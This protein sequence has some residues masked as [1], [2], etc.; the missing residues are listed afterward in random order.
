MGTYLHKFQNEIDFLEVYGSSENGYKEPWVGIVENLNSNLVSSVIISGGVNFNTWDY[1]NYPEG[2]TE[3]DFTDHTYDGE[4]YVISDDNPHDFCCSGGNGTIIY[5]IDYLLSE[6]IYNETNFAELESNNQYR[7]L[8]VKRNY[9]ERPL[10]KPITTYN[11]K[12]YVHFEVSLDTYGQTNLMVFNYKPKDIIFTNP[13]DLINFTFI[14][15]NRTNGP[16]T[17]YIFGYYDITTNE[18][19][20]YN[21]IQEE[22]E[23]QPLDITK[24]TIEVMGNSSLAET[25]EDSPD[26][27]DS[28]LNYFKNNHSITIQVR[29]TQ[30]I[31]NVT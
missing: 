6:G 28:I 3:S 4:Y 23:Q 14:G 30:I 16:S 15:P 5:V 2:P 1:K 11:K 20:G 8:I 19:Y 26:I 7:L 25:Y 29:T 24:F 9:E 31:Q 18:F 12:N 27:L 13:E 10:I 17:T 21:T 22:E